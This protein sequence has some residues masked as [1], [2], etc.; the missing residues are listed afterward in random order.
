MRS[1]RV[2]IIRFFEMTI[3][4]NTLCKTTIRKLGAAGFQPDSLT[5]CTSIA[6]NGRCYPKHD[7]CHLILNLFL[8]NIISKF[9]GLEAET[10]TPPPKLARE[11]HDWN[12]ICQTQGMQIP[13][14]VTQPCIPA[15]YYTKTAVLR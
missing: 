13:P 10:E 6:D 8:G 4:D 9:D 15:P 12:N 7:I 11:K 1:N 3:T 5:L 2:R 14:P